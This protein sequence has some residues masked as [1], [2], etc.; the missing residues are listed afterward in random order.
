M[1]KLCVLLLLAWSLGGC[2]LLAA[3]V[4]GATVQNDHDRFCAH[5]PYAADCR[6]N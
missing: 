6:W 1:M 2:A 5:H 3:G 4:I